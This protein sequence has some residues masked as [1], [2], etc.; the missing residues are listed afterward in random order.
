MKAAKTLAMLVKAA[1]LH[2]QGK[3]L[4]AAE[5]LQQ[6]ADEDLELVQ[7]LVSNIEH[8]E[9]EEDE[10]VAKRAT[11]ARRQRAAK[12]S[13]RVSVKA[14]DEVLDDAELEEAEDLDLDGEESASFKAMAS[15][16]TAK[17]TASDEADELEEASDEDLEEFDAEAAKVL[18]TRRALAKVRR[19]K[20]S[21]K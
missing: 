1:V 12:I 10:E 19:A 7:E 16:M 17:V 18:A 4:A 3:L 14:S 2:K 8:A 9:A 13:S 11:A 20:A 6:A 21:A 5:E 15:L